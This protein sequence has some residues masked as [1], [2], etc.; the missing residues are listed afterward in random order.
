MSAGSEDDMDMEDI[1][2][3]DAV[4]NPKVEI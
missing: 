1:A 2:G 3:S 4:V